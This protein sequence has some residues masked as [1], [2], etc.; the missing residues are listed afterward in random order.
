[1]SS[2]GVF[3]V[4]R[5]VFDHPA[6]KKEPFTECQAWIWLLAQAAWKPRCVRAVNGRTVEMINIDR[7]Q[8]SCSRYFMQKALRWASE[9][10]VRTFLKRLETDAM[11]IQHTDAQQA[12]ITIRNY[13]EFQFA[14][15]QTGAPET[16]AQTDTQSDAQT[17]AQTTN[18]KQLQMLE[19]SIQQETNGRTSGRTNGRTNGPESKKDNNFKKESIGRSLG[20]E[21]WYSL[22]PRKRQPDAARRAYNRIIASGRIGRADLIAKTKAFAAEWKRSK[23]DLKFCPYPA[24]WLSDGG[25][26]DEVAVDAGSG[27]PSPSRDPATFSDVEWQQRLAG[28]KTSGTWSGIWGSAPGQPG[29]L[30]PRHLLVVSAAGLLS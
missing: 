19:I 3:A 17:D 25:F 22:W 2:R 16:D 24:K 6:F 9:K 5:D 7:G 13:D 10:K 18:A 29:C 4:S 12:V 20:F 11:I 23:Q 27:P 8:L 26:D 1:M 28:F 21:E 14:P 30:V 15:K